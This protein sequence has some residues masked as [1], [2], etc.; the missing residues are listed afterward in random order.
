[1]ALTYRIRAL[2]LAFAGL[3]CAPGVHAEDTRYPAKPI[4]LVVPYAPGGP[5]DLVGR[6]LAAALARQLGQPVVVENKAGAGGVIGASS[7]VNAAPDGYTLLLGLQ[8]PITIN[9]ALTKV[10]YDPFRDLIAVRMIATSP[11]ILMASKKSGIGTLGDISTRAKAGS[12]GLNIGSSG[13]GTLPHVAAE[14]IK[15][16]TGANLVHVPYKGAGP[17]LI[18]L[19][20]GHIDLLFSDLQVGLPY[21]QSG[22]AT[23]LAVTSSQR[24]SMLPNVPTLAESG[25]GKVKLAGWYGIFAPRGTPAAILSALDR[26]VDGVFRDTAFKQTLE[27]QGSTPSALGGAKFV[28]FLRAEYGQWSRLGQSITIK[29]D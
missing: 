20:A 28:E 27:N 3:C 24:S 13:T 25:L 16:E 21:V 18:D 15:H 17:A 19:H 12:A 9:P 14:L 22:Q 1:M 4:K 11:M 7:V 8:G 2:C 29:M 26:A 6:S 5:T 10:P 23:A